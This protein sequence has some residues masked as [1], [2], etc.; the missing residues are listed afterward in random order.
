[1]SLHCRLKRLEK[2]TNATGCPGCANRR[3]TIHQ[4]YQLPNAETVTL[5]PI[6]D[7][8]PCTCG[9]RQREKRIAFIIIRR[10]GTVESTEEAERRYTKYAANHRPWEP[11][12]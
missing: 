5:P 7:L 10:P 12:R 2:S 8:P 6:P 3:T 4:E 1:M 9:R 11:N